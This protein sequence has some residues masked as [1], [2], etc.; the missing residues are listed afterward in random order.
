MSS[1]FQ[2][3]AFIEVSNAQPAWSKHPSNSAHH[4]L[5]PSVAAEGIKSLT[6][7]GVLQRSVRDADSWTATDQY[8][9]RMEQ[10]LERLSITSCTTAQTIDRVDL[11]PFMK[12]AP[13]PQFGGPEIGGASRRFRSSSDRH[14]STMAATLGEPN[15]GSD[16]LRPK[17]KQGR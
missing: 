13:P 3:R 5:E 14:A 2:L 12:M 9:G 8:E 15:L 10:G 17:P 4:E 1:P 11:A 6:S 7:R 16:T